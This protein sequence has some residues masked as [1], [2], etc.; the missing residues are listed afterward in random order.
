MLKSKFL[1]AAA[2]VAALTITSHGIAQTPNDPHHANQT[3]TDVKPQPGMQSPMMMQMMGNM[4]NMMEM[5]MG[6]G[7]QMSMSGMG[8]SRMGMADHLEGRIAFVRAELR[9]TDAQVKAWDDFANAIRESAKRMANPTMPEMPA[10][11]PELLAKL[12]AQEKLLSAKIEAVQALK[13]AF[14]PLHDVLTAEQ[15]KLAS[16]LLTAH[17]GLIPLDMMPGGMMRMQQVAQ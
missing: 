13:T 14:L 1:A 8:M 4:M 5:M 2:L 6:G 9:I 17:M 7:G 15:R 10:S 16:D 3:T 11:P 12:E